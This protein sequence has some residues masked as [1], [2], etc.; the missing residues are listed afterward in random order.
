[1][2]AAPFPILTDSFYIVR[3]YIKISNYL[4]DYTL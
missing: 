3:T 1:M 4:H 2:L